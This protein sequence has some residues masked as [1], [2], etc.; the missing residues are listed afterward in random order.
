M[1]PLVPSSGNRSLRSRICLRTVPIAFLL[2]LVASIY[3]VRS[4]SD[5]FRKQIESQVRADSLHLSEVVER[6]LANSMDACAAVAANEV[7][8]NSIIDAEH[9]KSTLQSFMRSVRLPGA[10]ARNI[11]MT[12]YQG[13]PI[14]SKKPLPDPPSRLEAPWMTKVMRGKRVVNIDGSQL[15]IAHPVLYSGQPE[16]AILATYELT[17]FFGDLCIGTPTSA[18]VICYEDA[19]VATSG[20]AFVDGFEHVT[21]PDDWLMDTSPVRNLPGLSVV[22]LKSNAVAQQASGTVRRSL[23]LVMVAAL[24]VLLAGLWMGTSMATGAIHDFLSAIDDV[25]ANYNLDRRVNVD[26]SSEFVLLGDRFNGML[27]EINKSTVSRDE[28]RIPALV[29]KYTD[30]AVVVTDATGHIEWVNEGFTRVTGYAIEEVVGLK[31]GSFLQGPET[32]PESVLKMRSAVRAS[33][34]VNVEILNYHKSGESYWVD[35][36]IRPI[37]SDSGELI[38]FIAIESDI[39]NRM[40][41]AAEREH[42]NRRMVD[43]SRQA[44]KAEVA[45]GVL[46]NV[47]NAL[48]S[49]SVSA[50]V[51]MHSFVKS[52]ATT[53]LSRIASVIAEHEEQLPEFFATDRGRQFPAVVRDLLAS[54]DKERGAGREEAE[55]L[56]R[57]IEHIKRAVTKQ[58]TNARGH[59]LCEMVDVN[60]LACEARRIRHSLIEASGAV[61]DESLE[62][63]SEA[64]ADRH[65]TIEIMENLIGNAIQATE[66]NSHDDRR[67]SI[68]TY[69]SADGYI[70]FSVSDNGIGISSENLQKIFNHGFTTREAGHGFGLHASILAAESM[71]ATLTAAS[72]GV[73]KG[74]EFV[75]QLPTRPI[76]TR[77]EEEVTAHAS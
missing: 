72:D 1:N 75:L 53:M 38:K 10:A 2:L 74:A 60:E 6:R 18:S 48:T 9:R 47:G 22:A 16:A 55:R 41:A 13:V 36:E 54:M 45:T 25:R 51:L 69:D 35:V 15:T 33:E 34:G 7:V 70:G 11:V 3:P 12:D 4:V 62:S 58:Q 40:E 5:E 8:V 57:S 27:E 50:N 65:M 26:T 73:G 39:T 68:R 23:L 19:V 59:V 71:G 49:V 44:G 67:V 46:H 64:Y 24:A 28:H 14:A 61:I 32:D 52:R 43:L 31:P 76:T 63:N 56:I 37:H 21:V 29:A 77:E 17:A 30:N 42:L 20:D 66:Q